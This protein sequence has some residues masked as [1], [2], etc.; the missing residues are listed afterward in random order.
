L[1]RNDKCGHFPRT[2]DAKNFVT[3]ESNSVAQTAKGSGPWFDLHENI[4]MHTD[5][6]TDRVAP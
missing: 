5:T 1:N 2:S 3:N 4:S 6:L